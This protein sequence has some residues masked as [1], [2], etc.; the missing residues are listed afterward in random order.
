MGCLGEYKDG[1]KKG[2]FNESKEKYRQDIQE[3]GEIAYQVLRPNC[4]SNFVSRYN[5]L[6]GVPVAL[7]VKSK[8]R[9][10]TEAIRT[11]SQPSKQ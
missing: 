11:Q 5:Y 1:K 10:G 7:K 2:R 9:S 4:L 6:V 3:A 8:Q